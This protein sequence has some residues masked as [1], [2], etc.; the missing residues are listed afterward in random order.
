MERPLDAA[1]AVNVGNESK[2][3]ESNIGPI[4]LIELT[5]DIV[6]AYIGSNSLPASELAAL[7]RGIFGALSSVMET[8]AEVVP[9]PTP[10]WIAPRK[11][12]THDYLICLEDGR[13]FKSLK[14]YL[15]TK[16]NLSPEDYRAKWRPPGTYPMV[17]PAYAAKRSALA[18][19]SG[20]GAIGR[21]AKKLR[22]AARRST[23]GTSA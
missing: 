11:S 1:K 3:S 22:P 6:A 19:A 18:K 20:L 5:A 16:Y 4:S 10:P 15:R 17:A 7:I 8:T 12:I 9:A 14:R 13:K 23:A 21:A 2:L